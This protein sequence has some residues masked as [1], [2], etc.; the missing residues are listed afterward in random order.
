MKKFLSAILC[1]VLFICTVTEISAQDHYEM[2]DTGGDAGKLT[3]RF[4]TLTTET[5]LKSGDATILTSPDGKVMLIDAGY[6]DCG[7]Q[8][9]AA[10][11]A[12]GVTRI[13]YLVASHL[14]G[15]HVGGF[16]TV[17]RAFEVGQVI[18]SCLEYPNE[19]VLA[20]LDEIEL[21]GID[22][23]RMSMGDAFSFGGNVRVEILWPEKDMPVVTD[24]SIDSDAFV[25]DR[26]LLMKITYGESTMLFGGDLYVGG[27]W[28]V[29]SLYGEYLDCDILKAN[30]HG[31]RTSSSKPFL[32]AVSPLITVMTA[33]QLE[34]VF[35]YKKF[36]EI[37]SDVYVTYYHGNV[38]VSTEG[39]GGYQVLTDFEWN[40]SF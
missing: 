11:R 2:F 7:E 10:L 15:D 24:F 16:V 27:E 20:I 34:D 21:Q 35:T 26:S 8:V 4:L 39:D 25:N 1:S 28:K 40:P 14:H 37:G 36:R 19:R 33:D 31:D 23:T 3:A 38:R 9:V 17:M 29:V 13:D 12:M 32:N 22:Y 5:G 30:H 6:D 18:T